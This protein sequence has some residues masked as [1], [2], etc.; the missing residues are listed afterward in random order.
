MDYQQA[1]D[2]IYGFVNYETMPMPRSAAH[3][4]LRRMDE[5]MLRLGNPHQAA[6][7]VHI[8]GTK[9]KGS[10]A[11]MIASVLTAAGYRTGLNTSPHLIDLRERIKVDDKLITEEE[12]IA[13]VEKL[14]PEIEVVNR[15]AT[16]GE[17]TTFEVL[18][19]ITFAYFRE[20]EV[21]F[22]VLEVGLGG[23]LDATNIINPEV[24]VI[25]AISYDHTEVL[26]DTLTEIATE[27]AGIIK[28]N[29]VVV[30]SPQTDEAATVIAKTCVK[31]GVKLVRVDRDVTWRSTGFDLDRQLFEVR[32]R[33]GGYHLSIPLL[34]RYQLENAATAVAALEVLIEKG[35][36]ISQESIARGL[37][38]VSWPGRFQIL[39]RHPLLVADGA[40]NA[41][42][43][44]KLKQSLE[45]YFGLS[46]HRSR[47]G[48]AS[49][50]TL[51]LIER[52][53]LII[54]ASFDKNMTGMVSELW[55]LFDR[56]IVTRSRHPR[57]AAP[58][59]LVTEF[60]RYGI[61]AQVADDVPAALSR[62]KALA[63]ERD[64]I[65]VTGSLFVVGEAIEQL[66]A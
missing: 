57:A 2:Y 18:T 31:R 21:D 30:T 66:T 63:G 48:V 6:R 19:A 51:S 4:D 50:G 9:G 20:K 23:R 10:T 65:C 5:L 12:L 56:V 49:G 45:Q 52:A 41:D 14:K 64:I 16:Y 22:Q 24:A 7:S 3:F 28:P 11:A 37:A 42:S 43:V 34:G 55:P 61:E 1:L 25:T 40:H 38:R 62:A 17:L 13:M 39:N 47:Q 60:A 26:G 54:G 58:E 59:A 36:N 29:S 46:P 27:K 32:G 15:S 8:A 44:Q 35:F 53:I 33:L